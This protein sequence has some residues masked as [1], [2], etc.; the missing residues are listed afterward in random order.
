MNFENQYLKV[1]KPV[2]R[3]S[4][5]QLIPE[6]VGIFDQNL[7]TQTD[8][9][10]SHIA[11]YSKLGGISPYRNSGKKSPAKTENEICALTS[12]DNIN[13]EILRTDS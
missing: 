2:E 9:T 12:F 5:Y 3:Q 8:K 13:E 11:S 7:P 10:S 4:S 6:N 1:N